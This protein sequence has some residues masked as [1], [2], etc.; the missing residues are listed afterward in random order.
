[1]NTS[2]C[3]I[4]RH[5]FESITLPFELDLENT[6]VIG[7]FNPPNKLVNSKYVLTEA[8]LIPESYYETI[9]IYKLNKDII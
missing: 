8:E 5:E 2:S 4:N 1:M 6:P 7:N 9:K 3:N